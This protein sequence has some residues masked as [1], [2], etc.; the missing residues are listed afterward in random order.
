MPK[1]A[2]SGRHA[3]LGFGFRQ[4]EESSA[5]T[6]C[7]DDHMKY[8]RRKKQAEA[9]REKYEEADLNADGDA[10]TAADGN[11]ERFG[12]KEG[13]KIT[14]SI[15]G[16]GAG[17]RAK[18]ADGPAS[19]STPGGTGGLAERLQ[20]MK[21]ERGASTA[22]KLNLPPPPPGS[23]QHPKPCAMTVTPPP[24]APAFDDDDD[25]GDDFGDFQS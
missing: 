11:S 14:I 19:S 4:R 17:A 18:G 9:M 13:Q 10:S 20:K 7:L 15:G 24:A 12:L 3:F 21:L 2:G 8:L 6:A 1:H 5:F 22:L 16:A 25:F 23:G